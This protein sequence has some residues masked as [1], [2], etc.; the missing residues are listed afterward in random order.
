M[1]AV[2]FNLAKRPN[3]KKYRATQTAVGLHNVRSTVEMELRVLTVPFPYEHAEVSSSLPSLATLQEVS[4]VQLVQIKAKASNITGIKQIKG[5][6][7][8]TLQTQEVILLDH[9]T[10]IK[11]IMWQENC[12]KLHKEKNPQSK[13]WTEG[14][15]WHKILK[16]CQI[17]AVC[18][19]R[20]FSIHTATSNSNNRDG[21]I[22]T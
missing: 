3:L 11:L 15:Q 17:Q 2:C 14:V 9:T 10:S 21:V 7:G 22:V 4:I 20:N 5:C 18:V 12:D 16:H 19:L 8:Q 13:Y 6:Y 1:R